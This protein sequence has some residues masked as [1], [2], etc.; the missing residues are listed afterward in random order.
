MY[1]D[2]LR[3]LR[4]KLEEKAASIK[5]YSVLDTVDVPLNIHELEY[6]INYLLLVDRRK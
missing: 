4:K 2:E 1:I 5:G 3:T 6:I